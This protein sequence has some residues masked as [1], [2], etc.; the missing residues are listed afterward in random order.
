[1]Q[2]I[3]LFLISLFS[4]ASLWSG[5]IGQRATVALRDGKVI[6]DW[7]V[8]KWDL[9]T[10]VVS[11]D[12]GKVQSSVPS[13]SVVSVEY[14]MANVSAYEHGRVF[15]EKLKFEDAAKSFESAG[16]GALAHAGRVQAL[17]MAG[18]AWEK[19]GKWDQ[20][21]AAFKKIATTYGEW[22]YA[23]D[24]RVRLGRALARSGKIEEAEKV[25]CDLEAEAP[26]IASKRWKTLTLSK[27]LFGLS[28]VARAKAAKTPEKDLTP[29]AAK[30]LEALD[31]Q[32]SSDDPETWGAGA[33]QLLSDYR[34][35]KDAAKAKALAQR[36]CY[37]P[38]DEGIRA[39]A[40]LF[41]AQSADAKTN[42]LEVVDYALVAMTLAPSNDPTR[43]TAKALA[44][45]AKNDCIKNA[46]I[47]EDIK[48]EL[49]RYLENR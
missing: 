7:S 49:V 26:K 19:A 9:Q 16:S 37:Q 32:A 1:M 13:D 36:I 23:L 8:V 12:G 4:L 18:D 29:A 48:K 17:I 33:L 5:E 25:L 15:L 3:F 45:S 2:R 47:S 20:S 6:T 27:V 41:L 10:L 38:I 24:A 30:L 40:F 44:N 46:S 43:V 42:P 34:T 39:K 28:E 11:T 21:A 22:V 14:N 35:M 31:S